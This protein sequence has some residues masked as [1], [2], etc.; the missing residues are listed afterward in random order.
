[1]SAGFEPSTTPQRALCAALALLLS[2]AWLIA[3][4]AI[5]THTSSV[6]A[7]VAVASALSAPSATHLE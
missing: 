4:V 1:M 3:A 2:P 6:S 5:A 7:E